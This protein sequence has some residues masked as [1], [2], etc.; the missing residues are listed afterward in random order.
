MAG[1][2]PRQLA[3][4]FLALHVD[5]SSLSPDSLDSMRP[6]HAGVKEGYPSESG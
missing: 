5:F 2:R 4:E 6:A 3:Y 1:D